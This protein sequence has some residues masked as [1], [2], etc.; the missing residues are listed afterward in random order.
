MSLILH[1][2]VSE[3]MKRPNPC[4]ANGAVGEASRAH[5]SGKRRF[6]PSR[7]P[8]EETKGPSF[9]SLS[10]GGDPL[11]ASEDE[12]DMLPH[13]RAEWLFKNLQ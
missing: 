8:Q 11:H 13:S 7:Q 1:P 10:L 6:L 2:S 9:V 4:Q 3:R 12:N 5:A